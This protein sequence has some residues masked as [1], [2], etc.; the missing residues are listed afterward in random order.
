MSEAKRELYRLWCE[1]DIGHEN[2]VFKSKESALRWAE[3]Y[4]YYSD[5]EEPLES[6]LS[7]GLIGT[8][9]VELIGDKDE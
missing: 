6:L 5:V 2:I 4:L 1:W 9:S 3:S 8:T 7:Q